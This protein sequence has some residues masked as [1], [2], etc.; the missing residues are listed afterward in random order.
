MLKRTLIAVTALLGFGLSAASQ[1][2]VV[3]QGKGNA[4]ALTVT[5]MMAGL[6]KPKHVDLKAGLEKETLTD[7]DWKA[8]ATHAALLNESSYILMQAN[9]SPD[10][11]WKEASQ[12]MR[13]GSAEVLKHLENKD[14]KAALASFEKIT[15]SCR[16]CHS[17][18][19]Q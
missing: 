6:V 7:E 15:Q 17:V 11:V 1:T 4:R 19:K 14:A 3:A 16:T 10:D 2:Q 9:R 18:H 5:Q 8:L 13:R 12:Q